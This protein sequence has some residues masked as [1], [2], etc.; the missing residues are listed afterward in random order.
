MRRPHVVEGAEQYFC[1]LDGKVKGLMMYLL[2]IASPPKAL[3]M[4]TSNFAG[5]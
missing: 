5:A 1:D 4:A 3:D 2:S